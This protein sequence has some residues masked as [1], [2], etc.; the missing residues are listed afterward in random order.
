ML[1]CADEQCLETPHQ[2][3][4]AQPE[5]LRSQHWKLIVK[6]DNEKCVTFICNRNCPEFRKVKMDH[7]TTHILGLT[8]YG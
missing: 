2:S 3:D 7:C 1:T 6:I 8:C 5:R 4:F